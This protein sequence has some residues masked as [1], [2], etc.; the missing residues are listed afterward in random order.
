MKDFIGL[1]A[2]K[3][4]MPVRLEVV[5][6][7]RKTLILYFRCCHTHLE[8]PVHSRDWSKWL[9]VGYQLLVAGQ[10]VIDIGKGDIISLVETGITALQEIYGAFKSR[11]DDDFNTYISNSFLTSAEQVSVCG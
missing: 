3:L 2:Q 11:D 1:I 10:M 5:G 9:K 8:L 4:P 7:M 6:K